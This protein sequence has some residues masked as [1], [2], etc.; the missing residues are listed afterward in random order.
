MGKKEFYEEL[1]SEEVEAERELNARELK[2]MAT[3]AGQTD[4][5]VN[6][7]RENGYSVKKIAEILGIPRTTLASRL[8]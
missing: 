3:K 6:H 7:L 8:N 1:G 4:I 5:L 2:V